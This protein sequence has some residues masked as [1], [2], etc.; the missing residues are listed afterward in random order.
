MAQFNYETIKRKIK[1]RRIIM[2]YETFY[3]YCKDKSP[4]DTNRVVA[5]VNEM[6][7]DIIANLLDEGYT[8]KNFEYD[9]SSLDRLGI[10]VYYE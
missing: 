4:E 8:I 3:E 5:K 7:L 10:K 9:T 1:E 6:G 2:K